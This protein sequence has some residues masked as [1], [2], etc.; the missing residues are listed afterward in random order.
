MFRNYLKI[1]FRNITKRKGFSAINIIGLG[2][3]IACVLIFLWVQNQLSYDRFHK[4]SNFLYGYYFSNN[5]N[6][7]PPL[8]ADYLKNEYSQILNTTRFAQSGRTRVQS[9]DKKIMQSDIRFVDPAFVDMF[10]LQFIQGNPATAL[11]HPLSVVL[12]QSVAK[13]YF[14]VNDPIGE[15]LTVY[16]RDLSVTGIIKDYPTNSH[17]FF[18]ILMPFELL[19]QMSADLKSWE[20]NWH[21]TYVQLHPKADLKILNEKISRLIQKFDKTEER[22]Q[23]LRPITRLHLYRLQGGGRI[24]I[25]NAFSIIAI[26]ILLIACINFINLSTAQ[27]SLRMKEVG[28]RKTI[29]A[30]K[31]GLVIQF[32]IE[33][34]MLIFIAWLVGLAVLRLFLPEFNNLVREQFTFQSLLKWP[35]MSGIFG[36]LLLSGLIAG[37]YPAHVLSSFKPVD[38]FKGTIGR[39]ARGAVFRKGLVIFQFILSIAL[40]F[41]TLVLSKQI[42]FVQNAPLGFNKDQVVTF[43]AGDRLKSFSAFKNDILAHTD[44]E[45]ITTT[46]IPPYRW[47]TN[48]GLGDVYWE[49]QKLGK[50]RMV[51]TTVDHDYAKTFGLKIVDGRFF[52]T[53]HLTDVNEAWVVNEA[54]VRA[55]NMK[56]PVG[57][58]LALWDNKR[59]IIGVVKDYHFESLRNEI[60]PM[61]MRVVPNS[62]WVCIKIKGQN[63]PA[64][65]E[66]IESQWK[67]HSDNHPFE[68]NFLNE[69]IDSQYSTEVRMGRL[70]RY[71]SILAIIISCLGLFGL[72]SYFSQGRTKEIGIRK[73]LGSSTGA[74]LV[75]L[76]KNFIKWVVYAMFIAWPIAWFL[77]NRLLQSYAYKISI[78]WIF[79]ALSGSLALLIALLTVSYQTIKTARANPVESLRHE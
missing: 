44:I 22:T 77:M 24:T 1:A 26:F 19:G 32:F 57:K 78:G 61:A 60:M 70:F 63:I 35:V 27:S 72:A 62:P 76:S 43:W 20:N 37:S 5:S 14:G 74:L 40:I 10:S 33:T 54:A 12:T 2:V 34:F 39:G 53:E 49:G 52:S 50:I 8:L 17:L 42:E 3:G 71:F 31:K 58:W 56:S 13:K 51:E 38:I 18:K 28:V 25:V 45:S 6:S 29:G 65:L 67:I 79:F 69:Q 75:L 36:L 30:R 73:V 41:G 68:Y 15:T 55:M 64:T 48:A 16:E 11:S 9:K 7:T 66:F 59:P 4:N 21:Q 23:L 47:N 46:N